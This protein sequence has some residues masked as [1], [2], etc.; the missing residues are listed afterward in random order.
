MRLPRSPTT[1]PRETEQAAQHD[2][3]PLFTATPIAPLDSHFQVAEYT[4]PGAYF[5]PLCSPVL[6][7]Q[8]QLPSVSDEL[9][10][11]IDISFYSDSG[12]TIVPLDTSTWQTAPTFDTTKVLRHSAVVKPQRGNKKSVV[13]TSSWAKKSQNSIGAQQSISTTPPARPFLVSNLINSLVSET[14][15]TVGTLVMLSEPLLSSQQRQLWWRAYFQLQREDHVNS[16]RIA[17]AWIRASNSSSIT[18]DTPD[19]KVAQVQAG[20]LI[21]WL[22]D[23]RPNHCAHATGSA[24]NLAAADRVLQ[25]LKVMQDTLKFKPGGFIWACLCSIA[26]V[27]FIFNLRQGVC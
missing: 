6:N 19:D 13:A 22:E 17:S 21:T 23:L 26:S 11:S 20:I 9:D 14:T 7:S 4:V 10:S 3:S 15:H 24:S 16:T 12:S 1:L 25:I 2:V 18:P 5:S 8:S 27:C